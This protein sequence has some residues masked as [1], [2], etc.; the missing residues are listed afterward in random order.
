MIQRPIAVLITTAALT[1]APSVF[2]QEAVKVC[3]TA[4][5]NGASLRKAG[6]FIEARKEYSGCAAE[7]CPG[8]VKA[9]CQK[10]VDELNTSIPG[11]VFDVKDP[12]GNSVAQVR[13]SIDGAPLVDHLDG[14]A[15]PVNPGSH[16]F[17]F[18]VA[19]QPPV[20]KTF[21]IAE[22]DKAHRE[23]VTLGTAPT[24]Q[25]TQAPQTT[26]NQPPN[27][28][29]AEPSH[30]G[31]YV[32]AAVVGLNFFYAP[33]TPFG[34]STNWAGFRPDIELGLHIGH[35]HQGFVLALRQSLQLTAFSALAGGASE[36][37]L[38]YDISVTLAKHEL[39]L[40]PY[41]VVGIGYVFD[42][43]TGFGGPSAGVVASGG[44]EAKFF[45]AGPLYAFARP[46][47][48][49]VQCYHDV[50]LCALALDFAAGVGVAFGSH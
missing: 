16:Q 37:R 9:E 22:G 28:D 38:G 19:G 15:V 34:T 50:G 29:S 26:P 4:N 5:D 27:D 49:G 40:D 36:L 35:G 42:G 14:L 45:I 18:E 43:L 20:E 48:V 11:V 33:Q 25:N 7:V 3:I 8:P 39:S 47:E 30:G 17:R 24:A 1:F 23:T 44:F 2:A 6:K 41:A 10:R 32:E 31:F 46:V 12:S 13:V 21:L